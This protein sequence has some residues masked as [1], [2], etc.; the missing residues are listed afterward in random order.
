MYEYPGYPGKK[1]PNKWLDVLKS[2]AVITTAILAVGILLY[3]I[4]LLYKNGYLD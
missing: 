4:W 3:V 2:T 1:K